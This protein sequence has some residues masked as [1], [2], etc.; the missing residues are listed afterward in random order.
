MDA[1]NRKDLVKLMWTADLFL[2]IQPVGN[3]TAVSGTLYEYWAVGKAPVL[4]ISEKGA[5]SSLVENY[6]IG[7]HFHFSEIEKCADYIEALYF[8]YLDATP[9]WVSREGLEN[10]DRRELAEQVEKVWRETLKKR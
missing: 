10:F 4:L 7:K 6:N 3:T 8:E 5:S 9:E 2:L 1:I